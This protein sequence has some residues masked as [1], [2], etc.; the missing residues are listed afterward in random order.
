MSA[1]MGGTR[2]Y[3]MHTTETMLRRALQTRGDATTVTLDP[4]FQGLPATAH[5]GAVLALIDAV[6]PRPGLR[7]LAGIFRRRVPLGTSLRLRVSDQGGGLACDLLDPDSAVLVEGRVDAEA[8]AAGD[9]A[10]PPA[11]MPLP[12]STTC[13]ACGVDSVQGLQAKLH[14]DDVSVTGRW[15]PPERF[16]GDAGTLAP[17]ALTVLLDEAA[18]W[19][20]AL[21]S[22]E[23]GMTTDLA[24]TLAGAVPFGAAVTVSGRR[25]GVRRAAGDPRYWETRVA[26]HDEDGRLVAAA[27]IT[28]VAVRGAARKLVRWLAPLNSRDVLRRIFPAYVS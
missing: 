8:A 12:I 28:F 13:F 18:F 17:I 11:A 4:V 26:A 25:E 3:R 19:L 24:V 20:G 2:D 22:G 23:S 21:A 9:E 10:L 5:G 27:D 7:R 6:L 16:R 15:V 1:R 14:F